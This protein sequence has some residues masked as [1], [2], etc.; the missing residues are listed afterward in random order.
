M[1]ISP[2]RRFKA[3]LFASA[4]LIAL[5]S[6]PALAADTDA[7]KTDDAATLPDLVIKGQ[8]DK[9][10]DNKLAPAF[11]GGQV[12]RGGRVGVLG[13][14]DIMD[15]P[16]T[17]TSYTEE[18]IRNQQASTIAD[19]LAN[20]PS[21]RTGF[22]FGNFS[23]QFIVRGFPL[24]AEDISIDGLY[25]MTPRQIVRLET[26][27]RVEVL[28]GAS[29]FLNGAAP[30][31]TGI[32]GG[33]NLVPKRAGDEA[34]TRVTGTYGMNGQF[35]GA[36]DSGMRFGANKEWGIRLNI[37][38]N[39]G[40]TSI[41]DEKR[42]F[43]LGA[44]ALDYRGEDTRVA[45]DLTTQK[46][47][48][49]K[50]R[51]VVYLGAVPDVPEAPDADT[52]YGADW[53]Y[54]TMRD[55]SAV[56][57]VEHD[58]TENLMVYVKGGYHD[59]REDGVYGSPTVSAMNGTATMSR[60]NVPREDQTSS[61]TGGIR[62]KFI[63]GGVD[64]ALN[65]G[66][67]TL[68][69][70]NHNSYEFGFSNPTN[71]YNP[72]AVAYP[73]TWFGGGSFSDLP[74][75]SRVKTSSAFISDTANFF[76]DRAHLTL[77]L[78]SQKL[79]IQSF[80]RTTFVNTD[81]YDESAVTPVAGL[82]VNVTEEVTLY[83]NRIE[84]LAQGPTAPLTSLNAG[85]VFA[86][87]KSTQ[88]EVGGKVDLGTLG[89]SVAVFQ[90]EQPIGIDGGAGTVFT[91]DGEQQNR[92]VE[93]SAYGELSEGLRLIGGVTWID[94]EQSKTL[95]GLNDGKTAA[96]VPEYQANF[97]TEYDL[98]FV[99]G[100][101]TMARVIYTSEQYF[102]ASN[103]LEVPSWARLDLG[104][105]YTLDAAGRPLTFNVTAE[106]V[107]NEAYWASAAG[108]YLTQ[109]KPLTAKVSVSTEF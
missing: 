17:S 76:S 67:A 27:E 53:S 59:M 108:G 32:G 75:V 60:L 99:K 40:E 13:N 105:R 72:P 45:L 97:T 81:D 15:V 38:G 78:R 47:N 106:N 88:Y 25:G 50:G 63:T 57:S 5:A 95:G 96:G 42:W 2:T 94:A 49:E 71:I 36:V 1:S 7:A 56:L 19:V 86:P 11:A 70:E 23:E 101:T 87:Y 91:V 54:S 82:A 92:G 109:G 18:T 107:T 24:Y 6:S 43:T 39:D 51:P 73:A 74:L 80:G 37:A 48:V 14:Q 79:H 4:G 62:A 100:V 103:S 35:G 29:A 69:T 34:I 102:N 58:L 61:A 55:S 68:T 93:L 30:S 28:N 65:L 10:E 46:L 3:I 41:E 83:A 64:H 20:N 16:F 12:A 85:E 66:V 22:G 31:G 8:S 90:T 77:G 33:I 89:F 98:P 84:G 44:A 21:V 26:L 104:A 9:V 52:N